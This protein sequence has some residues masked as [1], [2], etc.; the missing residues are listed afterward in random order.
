M[1][2]PA[3]KAL[4]RSIEADLRARSDP[5]RRRVTLGYFP[6]RLEILGVSAPGLREV[7]RSHRPAWRALSPEAVLALAGALHE[8]ETHEGRQGAYEILNA[9][10]DAAALLDTATVE[11][12]GAGNDNWA[13]VDAFATR[14]SGPAWREGRIPDAAVRAWA[15]S[16][17]RWWRRT[18]LVSTVA[19]NQR[20]RGGTGDT[21]RTVDICERLVED[22]DDLVV[23]GLSWAL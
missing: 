17:N 8:G 10:T 13:T 5:D 19:L 16:E 22:R 14:V 23:K 20:S 21:P 1:T 15:G 3:A 11:G 9:R 18:A 7:L 6:T 4:A 2:G 12:L